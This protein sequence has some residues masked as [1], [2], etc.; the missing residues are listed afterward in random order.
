M[1]FPLLSFLR[2]SLLLYGFLQLIEV[3]TVI[4]FLVAVLLLR[5]LVLLVSLLHL[6]LGLFEGRLR[7]QHAPSFLF[8]VLGK[9]RM[10]QDHGSQRQAVTQPLVID[11]F[12]STLVLELLLDAD[13]QHKSNEVDLHLPDLPRPQLV[14]FLEKHLHVQPKPQ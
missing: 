8:C 4:C 6:F 5:F 1:F 2:L 3:N 14:T 11:L 13:R 10:A 12:Y 9:H 7:R